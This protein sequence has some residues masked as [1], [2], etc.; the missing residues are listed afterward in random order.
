MH[1][2]GDVFEA[3]VAEIIEGEVEA[4]GGVFLDPGRDADP[5]GLGEGFEAGRDIDSVAEDVAILD[6]DIAD[7]DADAEFDAVVGFAGVALGHAPLPVGRAAQGVDDAGKL[8]EEPVPGGLDD[9]A[10][11][12]GD[13][14]VDQLGPERFQ[15]VEGAFLV[16]P[17]QARIARDISREDRRQPALDALSP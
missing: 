13:L 10:A 17:D 5:A 14:R 4:A 7:I 16:G 11:M 12:L 3:L 9:A 2:T 8:D 15:A 1:R 6:D